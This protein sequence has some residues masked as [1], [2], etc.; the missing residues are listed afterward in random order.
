MSKQKE[1][2]PIPTLY[3][4]EYFEDNGKIAYS[5]DL[6]KGRINYETDPNRNMVFFPLR[7]DKS[8]F[9]LILEGT[10]QSNGIIQSDQYMTHSFC[11]ELIDPEDTEAFEGLGD[12]VFL[13]YPWIIEDY[14]Y[15]SLVKKDKLWIKC[16]HKNGQYTFKH[17]FTTHQKKLTGFPIQSDMDLT[18]TAKLGGYVN[19]ENKTYGISLTLLKMEVLSPDQPSR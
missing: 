9:N 1:I 3:P 5:E 2:S 11:F 14:E 15:K 17:P 13:R 6:L 19:W 4:R 18:L 10:V 8:P 16:K 7:Y 12:V